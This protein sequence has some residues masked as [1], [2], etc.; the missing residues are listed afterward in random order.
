MDHGRPMLVL[1]AATPE[2]N[3]VLVFYRDRVVARDFVGNESTLY[4]AKTDKEC[5]HG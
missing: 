5:H 3:L 4:S 1:E 2:E